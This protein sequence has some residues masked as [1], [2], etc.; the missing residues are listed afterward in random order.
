MIQS[1]ERFVAWRYLRSSKKEGFVSVISGFSFLGIALGVATL[2]VV[3]SVMNGFR[4]ELM[5]RIL[6]F[7]SHLTVYVQDKS[8]DWN[9]IK[10]IPGVQSVNPFLDKQVICRTERGV[11]GAIVRCVTPQDA[12]EKKLIADHIVHGSMDR[13]QSPSHIVMGYQLARTLGVPVGGTVEVMG[14]EGQPTAFGTVPRV[15]TF[16]VAG[17]FDCGMYEYDSAFLLMQLSEGQNFFEIPEITAFEVFLENPEHVAQIKSKILELGPVVIQDWRETNSHFFKAIQVQGNVMFLIL[18]LI[19]IVAAFNIV[20]CLVMLVK[21]KTKDIAVL[22]TLGL[23]PSAIMRIFCYI[24]L[25]I[26]GMGTCVGGI[27]GLLFSYNVDTIRRGLEA[28]SGT[29]LFR[30]E[31]Y[32]LSTLPVRIDMRE[33]S[34][35]IG[36]ALLCSFLATLYPAWKASRLKP[37]EGLRYE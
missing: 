29:E 27:V 18:A 34:M 36:M 28:L 33:V 22:R 10:A 24:G 30:A 3:M 8:V 11:S 17:L 2:I 26:G 14:A 12:M 31:I 5:N 16:K 35:I 23:S 20:S 37:V 4:Y 25:W 32:F 13:F 19:V 7:N 15:Q 6:G 1:F 9:Q 21:D